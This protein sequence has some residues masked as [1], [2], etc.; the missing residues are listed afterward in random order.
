MDQTTTSR[1]LPAKFEWR[2]FFFLCALAIPAGLAVLPYSFA[3]GGGIDAIG[4]DM[5]QMANPEMTRI[6]L[7]AVTIVLTLIQTVMINWPLTGVGMLAARPLVLI[8]PI[9]SALL[10][11]R[12]IEVNVKKILGIGAVVGTVWGG[13]LL[14]LSE[15]VF[16]PLMAADL[17]GKQFTEQSPVFT[18]GQ[19]LLASFGAGF[20]EEVLLR[21]FL[22]SGL[23]WLGMRMLRKPMGR[24]S[25]WLL[26]T[27]NVLSALVFGLLHLPNALLVDMP[28]TFS[29][30]SSILLMNGMIGV[31]FGWLYW[32]YGLESA[33]LAHFMTDVV[34]KVV[35]VLFL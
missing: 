8:A 25:P 34:L 15:H 5:G 11:G 4:G 3:L 22:L 18:A 20:N 23:A 12:P 35:A 7:V 9:F 21:M 33:M 2:L 24:P 6:L 19:G 26:W 32:T 14:L 17:A 1:V 29:V 16:G 27:A 13:L 30:V 28:L 31:V 10:Y